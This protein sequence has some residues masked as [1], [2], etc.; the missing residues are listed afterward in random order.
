[1]TLSFVEA[2]RCHG[3][4]R[5]S[6]TPRSAP[7]HARVPGRSARP[8]SGRRALRLDR[9][10]GVGRRELLQVA[11]AGVDLEP[12]L[13]GLARRDGEAVELDALAG[14]RPDE[15]V[16]GEAARAPGGV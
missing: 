6:I 12:A 15:L 13:A 5:P 10:G 8:R 7:G 1:M 4:P 14:A 11:V 3:G 2:A 9:D 16:A